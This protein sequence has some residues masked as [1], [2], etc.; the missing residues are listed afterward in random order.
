MVVIGL[1]E[2]EYTVMEGMAVSVCVELMAGMLERQ[3][4]I[5]LAFMDG[6]AMGESPFGCGG[7]EV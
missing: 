4:M 3:A 6:T 7:V 2:M 1:V 5:N